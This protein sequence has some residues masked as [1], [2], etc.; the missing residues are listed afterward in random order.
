MEG[1]RRSGKDREEREIDEGMRGEE[2]E[3]R[4]EEVVG[5]KE[6]RKE[7]KG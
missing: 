5:M 1:G 4:K 6:G 3:G 2:D 7:E